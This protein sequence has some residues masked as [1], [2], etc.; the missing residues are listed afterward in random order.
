VSED[1]SLWPAIKKSLSQWTPL[2]FAPADVAYSAPVTG[3]QDPHSFLQWRV[4]HRSDTDEL[5][6]SMKLIADYSAGSDGR[7]RNCMDVGPDRIDRL[8]RDLDLCLAECKRLPAEGTA[9]IDR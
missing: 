9:D 1:L 5:F 8:T 4:K 2:G 3:G 6:V 7:V